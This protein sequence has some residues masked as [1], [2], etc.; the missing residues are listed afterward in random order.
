[1]KVENPRTWEEFE[2]ALRQIEEMRE[3]TKSQK[4]MT[5]SELL[6]RGHADSGWRLE[7]TLER[8]VTKPVSL[9][10]YYKLIWAAKSRV[11]TF[12]DKAWLIPS[13]EQ[14]EQWLQKQDHLFFFNFEAYDYFAYLRHHGF[15]SP[16]LDWTSSPYLAAFF[17]MDKVAKNIEQVSVYVYW[18]YPEGM[19][20]ASS[21]KPAIHGLGPNVK[22]HRRHFLQQSQY[23]VCTAIDN[24]KIVYARHEDVVSMNETKQD[25]LWKF[26][27]PVSERVKV[28]RKLNKMNINS[29]SLFGTEDRL[30]DTIATNEILLRNRDL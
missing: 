2:E 27:I 13:T 17:A 1:M 24:G 14:Y 30:M 29:F 5:V 18:E 22:V 11:E 16:L 3:K 23:T 15:P 6:Y 7:T 12:T 8:L 9:L 4:S 19:K 20:M 21:D 26:N 10:G 25:R 28:L